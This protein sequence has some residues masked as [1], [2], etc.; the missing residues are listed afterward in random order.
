[1][2]TPTASLRACIKVRPLVRRLGIIVGLGCSSRRSGPLARKWARAAAA[3]A[4]LIDQICTRIDSCRPPTIRPPRATPTC[5]LQL[6]AAGRFRRPGQHWAGS[7]RNGLGRWSGWG[8]AI[9]GLWLGDT[10]GLAGCA[11]GGGASPATHRQACVILGSAGRHDTAACDTVTEV[12]TDR[13]MV[14][15]NRS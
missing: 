9:A 3:S 15:S 8:G 6:P 1:M 12:R 10:G 5:T 7:A 14:V 2:V 11:G 13:S 4:E